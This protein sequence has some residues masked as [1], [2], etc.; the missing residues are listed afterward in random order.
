MWKRFWD[1]WVVSWVI[2]L[3]VGLMASP[4]VPYGYRI[5][6]FTC[7]LPIMT[8]ACCHFLYPIVLNPWREYSL[9]DHDCR[10]NASAALPILDVCWRSQLE[11]YILGARSRNFSFTVY[12]CLLMHA[13]LRVR[14]LLPTV[15]APAFVAVCWLVETTCHSGVRGRQPL[16][17]ATLAGGRV[18]HTN[19]TGQHPVTSV[20]PDHIS[21]HS[22]HTCNIPSTSDQRSSLPLVGPLRHVLQKL[23]AL[24]AEAAYRSDCV[25]SVG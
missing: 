18:P 6:N 23:H 9:R 11:Y 19:L 21:L 2:I 13:N 20:S 12:S 4:L 15:R 7:I 17:V 24:S 10:A 25:W 1:I 14:V 3:G 5:T 22:N 16:H 8:Q